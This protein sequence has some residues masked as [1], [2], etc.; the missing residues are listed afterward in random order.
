MYHAGGG[1]NAREGNSRMAIVAGWQEVT[2]GKEKRD[3]AK[4]EGMDETMGRDAPLFYTKNC[5]IWT[6]H[7]SCL[8]KSFFVWLRRC[9]RKG[10]Q[11]IAD[12]KYGQ[13]PLSMVH[14][15]KQLP[16]KKLHRKKKRGCGL[17]RNSHQDAAVFQATNKTTRLPPGMTSLLNY[18]LS[19]LWRCSPTL[20]VY[21]CRW[22]AFA[23]ISR[24]YR[25]T[26]SETSTVRTP[27]SRCSTE[28]SRR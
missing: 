17:S 18:C 2:G 6:Q 16:L 22:K 20:F 3:S 1:V 4:K 23:R 28:I 21:I 13:E 9:S 5:K 24:F 12:N 27:S 26:T 11:T 7:G 15:Y 10:T 8:S 14:D 19:K 25:R